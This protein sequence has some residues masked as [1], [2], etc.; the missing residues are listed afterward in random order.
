MAEERK[1]VLSLK[2][3]MYWIQ[4]DYDGLTTLTSTLIN[5]ATGVRYVG[6][7][8]NATANY[9]SRI[10]ANTS[11]LLAGP[12]NQSIRLDTSQFTNCMC[13][14]QNDN[15]ERRTS[16]RFDFMI[17]QY[18]EQDLDRIQTGTICA[19]AG[20]RLP[21]RWLLC[22]GREVSIAIYPAL[23]TA[24]CPDQ[25]PVWGVA[26]NNYF[27]LPDLRGRT[28]IGTGQGPNLTARNLGVPIGNETHILGSDEMPAHIHTASSS[29]VGGH[30]HAQINVCD[31]SQNWYPLFSF[32]NGGSSGYLAAAT[33]L[34]PNTLGHGSTPL[35]TSSDGMHSHVITIAPTGGINIAH[36]NM[37]PSLPL[38]YIIKT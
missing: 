34:F 37:Q 8:N 16:N 12:N 32:N 15:A 35:Q 21:E 38:T 24:I 30:Q 36:N 4:L 6:S 26:A 2:G 22:D 1:F 10:Q 9:I 5:L 3:K 31:A 14:D 28:I 23:Y 20:G 11:T 19:F 25:N 29:H 17:W 13:G 7:I 27:K 33:T 18:K